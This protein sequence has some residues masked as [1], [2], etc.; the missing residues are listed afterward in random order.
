MHRSYHLPV[1]SA[2][3][4]AMNNVPSETGGC[5]LHPRADS[6]LD[7][8]IQFLATSYDVKD[9]SIIKLLYNHQ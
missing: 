4:A 2:A 5:I 7:Q 9:S 1:S 3:L 6:D 8:D